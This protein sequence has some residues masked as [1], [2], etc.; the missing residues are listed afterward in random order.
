MQI[1]VAAQQKFLV[2]QIKNEL[3]VQAAELV[4][5]RKSTT[6]ELIKN[7]LEMHF[8]QSRSNKALFQDI[9]RIKQMNF[10]NPLA[11]V[12]RLQTHSVNMYSAINKNI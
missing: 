5:S 2:L 10:E 7:L 3:K 4:N 12:S 9:I 6:W 1:A 8:G 11:F